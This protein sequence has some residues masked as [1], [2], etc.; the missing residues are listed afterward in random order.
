MIAQQ[1]ALENSIKPPKWRLHIIR[2]LFFLNFIGL[3]FDN[4]SAILFPREQLDTLGGVAI[5]FWA[6]FSLRLWD[7]QCRG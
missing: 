5:S 7:K 1:Q 4:W 3:A 2:G 6:G